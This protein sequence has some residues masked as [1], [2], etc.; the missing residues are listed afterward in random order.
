[1]LE[2]C[3]FKSVA[4]SI[5][6]KGGKYLDTKGRIGTWR[7]TILKCEHSRQRPACKEYGGASIC[8]NGIRK[9]T[10]KDSDP[11]GYLKNIMRSC[12]YQVLKASSLRCADALK[13]HNG[14]AHTID[15]VGC[16]VAKVRQHLEAR[17]VD[18]TEWANQGQWHVDHIRPC[19]SFNLTQE[20]EPRKSFHFNNQQPLWA[21]TTCRRGS[22]TTRISALAP[23]LAPPMR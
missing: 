21:L 23:A 18:D 5:R 12:V 7:G 16:T 15:Y 19:A 14:R 11:S 17:C 13:E 20:E 8:E 2:L 6:S 10:C 3:H 9:C 1:M 22:S 4:K